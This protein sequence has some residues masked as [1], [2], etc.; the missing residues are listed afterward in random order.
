MSV[1]GCGAEVSKLMDVS[2]KDYV[3][4]ERGISNWLKK[5]VSQ[6][7]A[8]LK[9][10]DEALA[11]LA[12]ERTMVMRAID[13]QLGKAP[14]NEPVAEPV[15]PVFANREQTD[16]PEFKSW[17]GGA[18]FV[19][20]GE[21]HDFKSGKPVVVEVLHGTTNTDV[22]EFKRDK[23]NVEGDWGAGFYASNTTG[24]VE[25]NYANNDG[26][27]ITSRIER[28]AEQLEQDD[29]FEGDHGEAVR[30]ARAQLSDSAPNTMKLF[31]RFDNPAVVGG[32]N[33]TV[34][35]YSEAYNEELDEYEEPTGKLVDFVDA[36]RDIAPDYNISD[37]EVERAISKIW[38]DLDGEDGVKV[39]DVSKV[40]KGE[41]GDAFTDNGDS[42]SS[43]IVRK[44][45]EQIGFDGIVDQSVHSK[46]KNMKGMTPDTVHFIA[47]NPT[48][49]K[50]ATGNRG[51][52]DSTNPDIRFANKAQTGSLWEVPPDTKADK[53][54]YRLQN[55]RVDLKRVQEAITD[56]TKKPIAE[57]FDAVQAETLYAGRVANRSDNFLKLEAKPLLE[58]MAKNNVSM[59]ELSDYLL[60]RHAP[61]A[62]AQI[63]KLG[64]IPDGGAGKNSKG[65]LMTTKA[66]NDYIA[67]LSPGKK[68]L[69]QMLA[70]KVDDITQGTRDLLLD[71][72]LATKDEIANWQGAYKHYVPLYR[73][74][75]EQT[76]GSMHPA[77]QGFS[78]AGANSRRRMGSDKQVS[79]M[80]A[81]V[82]MQ[83]EAA[84]TRAEKNRVGMALYGLALTNPNPDFWTTIKPNMKSED[85]A[86][87]LQA[88]GVDPSHMVDIELAPT[89]RTINRKTGK[90]QTGVDP[91]YKQMENVLIIKVDGQD[92]ALVF[93][94]NNP[95]A[96]RL[97]AEL[98]NL[99]AHAPEAM[100]FVQRYM[101]AA[102]RFIASLATQYNPA[103][104]A[105]NVTRDTL[106]AMVNLTSTPLKGQQLKVLG[107]LTSAARG[108]AAEL[109]GKGSGE[110]SRLYRE[111]KEAGAQTG[112]R[113]ALRDPEERAKKLESELKHLSSAGKLTPRNAALGVLHVVDG[114]NTTLENTV[115][116]ATYK[117]ALDNGMSKAQAAKVA[118]ELTVDFNRK[119]TWSSSI[120]PM[121]AF[122]NAAVQG[123][124][125]TLITLMSKH[126]PAIVA[127]G[128]ALGVINA[129]MLAGAG[130]D[131]DEISDFAK[132]RAFIIPMGTTDD[133]K[134]KYLSVPLPMGMHVL[135][136]SGRVMTELALSGGKEWK[137][138]A[139]NA[140]G[141]LVGSF[142]PI[143]GGNPFKADGALKMALPTVLDPIADL[144]TGVD[145]AG[146]PISK[147]SKQERERDPRPGFQVGRESTERMPSGAVYKGI[148]EA[149]NTLSGGREFSKGYVSPTPEEVRYTTMVIGGGLLR[150][151]EKGA[152]A[153]IMKSRGENVK[154]HQIPL[155]G[156]FFGETDDESLQKTRFYKNS[157]KIAAL[158]AELR[159]LYQKGTPQKE[160]DAFIADN[161]M[162]QLFPMND[163]VNN[164]LAKLNK[165]AKE[166]I[167]D[168]QAM[169]KL[170]ADRADVMKILNQAVLKLEAAR[171]K[172]AVAESYNSLATKRE[173]EA[174]A[175]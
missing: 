20:L 104:G 103:F 52:F 106:G 165:M 173:E 71:E 42:A 72:G 22:T 74:D 135:P 44:A 87:S 149:I 65:V 175:Q 84:I 75:A 12:E 146:R 128:V 108:I 24:D 60:A 15:A 77:G 73:E 167:G 47:F 114:F 158:E 101:G 140:F 16:T 161:P 49:I 174:V 132:T 41:L 2:D 157:P 36:V 62:N 6:S 37:R 172:A 34:L 59:D 29:E 17:S 86:A 115:R 50:S 25:S 119:G 89:L 133:G 58:A 66:A 147:Q 76:D 55:G 31:M 99:D 111:F 63:A 69:M 134:K 3:R 57:A 107:N 160:T 8:Q 164:T 5:G 118:R 30:M 156:R 142:N 92:R 138:K 53:V 83:R 153:V 11:Q 38:E 4:I 94:R 136:N 105:V 70:K 151:I 10:V 27:D 109:S 152:N 139:F 145:F 124:A 91:R 40:L 80:L 163:K 159:A 129:M 137:E 127:G 81:H 98:K 113:E 51:T 162:V 39:S 35:D 90:V 93:N 21:S 9:A 7:K 150:E 170:D 26:P 14:A 144:A 102:T 68:V 126:G 33:E 171:D 143:G 46:F 32:K 61:E 48:Q 130:Y 64:Q 13:E 120:G 45:L 121:Y 19:P 88:M 141:E 155:S 56:V 54:I 67:N 125:R 116:L 169:K 23:A 79:N 123:N 1:L 95:R 131:D 148:A 122:F 110:W 28:L 97:I 117:V 168:V 43:E 112:Y 85:T 96:E 78:V 18:E 82:L 100:E 154:A 166:N